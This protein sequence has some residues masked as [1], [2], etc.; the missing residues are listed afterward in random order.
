L[1]IPSLANTTNTAALKA[2]NMTAQG[3]AR[4]TLAQKHL[5]AL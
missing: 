2:Q 5:Q 4:G 1:T 3:N